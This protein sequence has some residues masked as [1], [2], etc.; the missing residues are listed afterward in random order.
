MAS[1]QELVQDI[2]RRAD[3]NDNGRLSLEELRDFLGEDELNEEEFLALFNSIDA[4]HS[5]SIDTTELATYFQQHWGD[6]GH[7]FHAI[8]S[9][10]EPLAQC[11]THTYNVHQNG[12]PSD[13]AMARMFAR[14]IGGHLEQIV[15][16]LEL[17]H[18]AMA[19]EDEPRG[20]AGRV[21]RQIEVYADEA[22]SQLHDVEARIAAA[23]REAVHEAQANQNQWAV[24]ASLALLGLGLAAVAFRLVHKP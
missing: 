22:A 24:P 20:R 8:T 10:H 4:D 1:A 14:E 16:Q 19:P 15:D 6:F 3:K 12:S 9:I 2:F 13:R 17:A 7:M 23:V 21:V 11:L 5:G 18:R